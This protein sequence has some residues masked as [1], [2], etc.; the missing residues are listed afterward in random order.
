MDKRNTII[1]VLLMA[2]AV[3]LFI[4][5]SRQLREQAEHQQRIAEEQR[6]LDRQIEADESETAPATPV[7]PAHSLA[8]PVAPAPGESLA[9]P[10]PAAPTL[11]QPVSE[12]PAPVVEQ[13]PETFFTLE[14]EDVRIR[15][16]TRG[17]A[18]VDI[19]LLKYPETRDDP[20]P[21]V[22]N[23]HGQQP[24]LGLGLLGPDGSP[25]PYAP[26]FEVV[27]QTDT[28]LV[29]RHR[30]PDGL[31][32]LRGYSI[33]RARQQGLYDI[34]HETRFI[35]RATTPLDLRSLF[36][37][38]GLVPPTASDVF[39]EFLNFGYYSNE[40]AHFTGVKYF[41]GGRGFLGIGAK[42]PQSQFFT[43]VSPI[44]W[45]SLKNQFFAAVL[46]PADPALA[47]GVYATG[48][49]L[50]PDASDERMRLGMTGNIEFNLGRL[51]PEEERL[52]KFNYYVGPKEYNQLK[53]LGPT[54]SK[55][56]QFGFFGP[57]SLTLLLMLKA[58]YTVVPNWGVAIIILTIFIKLCLWPLTAIQVRSAKRMAKIQ[59]PMKALR[60]KYKDNPQK[61][62]AETMKLF[63]ENKVNPAAG[64]LPL[65]LQIPIFFGL[66]FMLKTS[67]ELRFAGF[68][69]IKDLSLPDTIASIPET[70]A[71]LGGFPI[72]ILPLF[73]AISMFFQMRMTPTP[74]TD[75]LQRKIF[76]MMPF[77]FLIFCYNFPSGLV[78]YWTVQN[79]LTILQQYLTNR[80]KDDD[81]LPVVVTPAAASA[82][83]GSGKPSRKKKR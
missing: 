4:Y 52:L 53:A 34:I 9:S 72:N 76:Q 30:E 25:V 48:V 3:T 33:D 68:L 21:F 45:A 47:R 65:L 28:T 23:Q 80:R 74:V 1:G 63:K 82:S 66:F 6:L 59:E 11:A 73:M 55:V 15:F 61:M 20:A 36:I 46:T 18:I 22:F 8:A 32:I 58:I 50:S 31:E 43:S 69:W 56:M 44:E 71:L 41:L 29:F 62:Q 16:S 78:L 54:Q 7:A 57:I 51:A 14:N 2:A 77:I 26:D 24:A 70:V 19:A 17:A 75:N 10:A 38:M 12:T 83:K 49:E 39:G 37:G 13:T 81:P 40:K 60:E 35:N 5:Q 27:T 79:L 42:S 64:C 67:S